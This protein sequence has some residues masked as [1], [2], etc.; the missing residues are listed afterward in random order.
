MCQVKCQNCQEEFHVS[1]RDEH[2]CTWTHTFR[3]WQTLETVQGD[4]GV[5][6]KLEYL[7]A[8]IDVLRQA[9]NRSEQ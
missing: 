9:Q 3:P 4:A 8:E 6:V 7:A 5:Q 1:K 2:T